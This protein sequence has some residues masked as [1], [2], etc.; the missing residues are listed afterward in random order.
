MEKNE[1]K[2]V[3]AKS[4]MARLIE[5]T[6]AKRTLVIS[7][8]ILS[9]LASIA[10]FVPFIAI[11]YIISEIISI[12][13]DFHNL[14]VHKT[15]V[16]GWIALGGVIGNVLLYFA[17][18]M[19]SHLA[20]F[21]TLYILKLNFAAHIARLPLGFHLSF[22]SGK[23]RKVMDENIEKLEGFI[24][25]QLPD[26]VASMV[27]PVVMLVI[28]LAVDWRFGLAAAVGIVMAFAIQ[29]KAYGNEGAKAMADK[30]QATL[31]D[32]NNASVEYIRGISVVKAFNQTVYSFRQLHETIKAYTGFV[33][34]FT[35]SWENYMSAFSTVINNIYLFIIP[36]GI[37]IGLNTDDYRAYALTFIFYLV[38][39]PSIA[40][41]MM[42]ILYVTSGGMHIYG[43]IER[44]DYVLQQNIMPETDD[45]R[46]CEGSDIE[47]INVSFSYNQNSDAEALSNLSFKAR[48]GEITAVVGPSGGGKS[49]IAHLIP[50]F[51]DVDEGSIR[52]GGVDIK[53]MKLDYL[54][55]QVSFVFQDVFLF[56]QSIMENIR[57]GN[58]QASDEQVIAAAKAAQCQEFVEKLPDG[59]N[60]VIGTKGVHLSGGEKQRI[61]IARAIVKDA[62]VIV[63]DEATAF[64]DPEN[65]HLIQKAF[66]KLMQDK[67]VVI[68]AH[69]LSSIRSAHKIIVMD[70]GQ[71]VEQGTHQELLEQNGKYREM[72]DMY[73]E[74]LEWKIASRKGTAK[75]CIV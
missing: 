20:A 16:Y 2:D 28:L 62:P 24:A 64:A 19:C 46:T 36:V 15:L 50:R 37:L 35:L 32:M 60:T 47:F 65:E 41:V 8:A 57:I 73:T 72:W 58:K 75:K 38:F 22:G 66:E 54:M 52:I 13:P 44:M 1:K 4:G 7:S 48:Q 68:I 3:K 18:L 71:L 56:K 74:T 70:K 34:P 31:E 40:S 27:A 17:A 42:K 61:A 6:A 26:I 11:Y 43:G 59:Y 67:T 12:Y 63:L 14:D 53:D 49:T 21:G 69:R 9:A 45:P 51:F 33:L 55:G 5:L 39:V 29:I 23:L 10:A 25:H 30:Y